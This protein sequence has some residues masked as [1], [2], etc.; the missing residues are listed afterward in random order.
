M[1]EVYDSLIDLSDSLLSSPIF[2]IHDFKNPNSIKKIKL[3]EKTS[4]ISSQVTHVSFYYFPSK[5]SP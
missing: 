3:E 5:N 4:V 1:S 2:S